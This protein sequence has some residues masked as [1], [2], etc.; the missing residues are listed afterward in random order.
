MFDPKYLETS[1]KF[2]SDGLMKIQAVEDE[3]N[4]VYTIA[5]TQ[6]EHVIIKTPHSMPGRLSSQMEY[7]RW[8]IRVMKIL[9][10]I[11]SKDRTRNESIG[12]EDK[13]ERMRIMGG[14]DLVR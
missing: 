8:E 4:S 14:I 7:T 11:K 2:E 12:I 1:K 5:I 13:R 9:G 6:R 10:R 3:K